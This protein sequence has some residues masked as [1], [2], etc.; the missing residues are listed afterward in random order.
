MLQSDTRFCFNY[1][2]AEKSNG[3]KVSISW[4]EQSQ[5]NLKSNF[6]LGLKNLVTQYIVRQ[7]VELYQIS[8]NLGFLRILGF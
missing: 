4:S 1:Y 3:S 5:K 8:L 6:Y 2:G 7:V